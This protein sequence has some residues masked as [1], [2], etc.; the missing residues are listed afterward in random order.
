MANKAHKSTL[1]SP[2]RTREHIIASQSHNYIEKFFIDR[3]H[4][5]DRPTDYGTDVLVNTFD[6]NGYAEA[7]DIRI[8]LK[9]SDN[10]RFSSNGALI[11]FQIESKHYRL[12]KKQPMPV[13]LILYDAKVKKAYWLYLQEFFGAGLGRRPK[14]GAAKMT[15]HV[16]VKN[17]FSART[18]DYMRQRKAAI[19][20]DIEGKIRHDG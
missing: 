1:E 13:F 10:F 3:G 9:A 20:S 5:V 6:E 11:R 8:Q 4:T 18:V 2:R 7:G 16:P 17:K 15:V 19:L 12:W 14:K